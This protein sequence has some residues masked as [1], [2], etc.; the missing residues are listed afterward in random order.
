MTKKT[1]AGQA[2]RE[3]APDVR[4]EIEEVLETNGEDS[5]NEQPKDQGKFVPQ[6]Q[7]S[8]SQQMQ[9]RPGIPNGIPPSVSYSPTAASMPPSHS[10]SGSRPDPPEAP[11]VTG[12]RQ[13]PLRYFESG[14]GAAGRGGGQV[15][16]RG[17]GPPPPPPHH[18]HQ[19]PQYANHPTQQGYHHASYFGPPTPMNQPYGFPNH[20]EQ[21]TYQHH[22]QPH[23]QQQSYHHPHP[24]QYHPH[25]IHHPKQHLVG[26]SPHHPQPQFTAPQHLHLRN[27]P[28]ANEGNASVQNRDF[29]LT[30]SIGT[31][32]TMSDVTAMSQSALQR[33]DDDINFGESTRLN[34]NAPQAGP[35]SNQR[36]Q[37]AKQD[38]LGSSSIMIAD[39]LASNQSFGMSAGSL[40]RTRSFPDL[41]LSTGNLLQS[42]ASD[43]DS[44]DCNQEGKQPL[45]TS[46]GSMMRPF[47]RKSSSA[48]SNISMT[49]FT[50]KSF[51][52]VRDRTDTMMSGINDTMSLMSF[53]SR[54][55]N[56]SER[57]NNSE[58]SSWIDNFNSMQSIH[59]DM[60][61]HRPLGDDGSVKSFLSDV[62]T[63]LNALDLA[64][65]LLPP[66]SMNDSYEYMSR[67]SEYSYMN[68][69]DP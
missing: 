62:S 69:P 8:S 37:F 45:K 55:E 40:G 41:M 63:E 17:R 53:A 57:E 16:G 60:L 33:L 11:G 31:E 52:Q 13:P 4:K 54:K 59:S 25:Q 7:P 23:F 29:P 39:L 14:R 34:P 26:W 50:F 12:Y 38:S 67:H 64:E 5:T 9:H 47:H 66:L 36:G 15:S 43:K 68:K 30:T 2:L 20:P 35:Y 22:P 32:F 10:S 46:G 61:P 24:Q 44:S 48:S 1:E 27:T 18:E 65:P 3:D 21:P 6:H 58:S 28:R 51:H 42:T 56:N 49:S 19:T